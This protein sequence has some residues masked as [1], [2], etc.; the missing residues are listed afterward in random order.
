MKITA[1]K[2]IVTCPRRNFVIVKIET[3]EPGLYGVGDATLNGRELSVATLLREHLAPLLLGRDPDRVEDVWQE[4][5]RGAYWRGG[6]I[7]MTALAG[8]DLAL[9]DIKG[10]RA[11]LPLYSLLGGRTRDGATAYSHAGGRDVLE[12]EDQARRLMEAGFRAV[13]AQVAVP[14]ASGTYGAGGHREAAAARWTSSDGQGMPDVERDW[15]PSRYL[16][17]VPPLF[18]HLRSTLGPEVALLHDV[19]SR[20]MPIEAARL[21]RELEPYHLLF[22]ED[23]L[24]PEHHD[25]FAVVRHASTTPVAM[26]ELFHSKYDCL[27][28]IT[29]QWID[30]IR[31]DIGHIG[32][33]TE[34][35]KIAAIAEPYQVKTAWHGPGDI[36]P[37]THAA[38]VHLDCAIP[39]FGVQEWV[40][41]IYWPEV[42]E[43]MPHSIRF[44]R[45]TIYP[46]EVP[47]LGVD[48]DEA[49]AARYPYS[50][51]YLPMVRREDGSVHDW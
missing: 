43:V 16:Q 34:A 46:P 32:G 45:G 10:K 14:G 13:R 25:S 40:D 17:V 35:R 21:A 18:D 36:G 26:G 49:A 33:L 37:P 41:T 27:R 11:G 22:L 51:A 48:I 6:P 47:G 23:P 20:L 4:T 15:E 5:F 38:N 30:Y 50:R 3:S 44:D 24:R 19:H 28:L 2:V 12:A 8:I 9:W 39:N 29:N 42:M 7:Q 1:V 31:C